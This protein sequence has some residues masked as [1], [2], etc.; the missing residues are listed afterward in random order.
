M[1]RTHLRITISIAVLLLTSVLYGEPI[2][3]TD[4]PLGSARF[5]PT[6]ERP[7]GWRGDG[8]GKYPGAHPP[9]HWGRQLKQLRDL[10]CAAAFK[11][12]S[13]LSGTPAELGFFTDW[14]VAGPIESTTNA[15]AVIKDELL[16]G[17]SA[18]APQP[19]DKL[20]SVTWQAVKV[21]DSYIDVWKTLGGLT[22]GQAA[23]AQTCLY[24]T[25]PV[26]IW[27]HLKYEKGVT[28]WL[29]GEL[30]HSACLT[31]FGNAGTTLALDLRPGWNRFLF[32]L[33]P[34]CTT[35]ED[36]PAACYIRNRFWPE[37]GARDYAEQNIAWIASMPGLSQDTPVIAGDRIFT[38][39][40]P[41]N[42]V[43]LNKQTGKILW[44]R[45]N[46]TYDAATQEE[47]K[48]KPELFAKMDA[49]AKQ[50]EQYYQNFIEGKFP[51]PHGVQA[52]EE[53]EGELD[54]LMVE[55]D[56]K[57]KK[58][59]QQ[60]EPDWWTIPTP[61]TDGKNI[62]VWLTR[63]IS[64]AYDLNGQRRWIS[65]SLPKGQHHGYFCSPVIAD[66]KFIR[67]DGS[68]TAFDIGTG[69]VKWS[70]D[71]GK[72]TNHSALLWFGSL[73]RGGIIGGTEYI[74]GPGQAILIRARDGQV[75]GS[76]G[77]GDST[78]VFT[79]DKLVATYQQGVYTSLVN[80]NATGELTITPGK[81]L[82]WPYKQL[83]G[84]P[85]FYQGHWLEA[86]PLIHDGL[87][88]AVSGSGVLVVFDLATMQPVYEKALSLDLFHGAKGRDFFGANVTLAGPYIYLMGS[89]GVTLVIKPG[90]KYEEVA[91]NRIQFF[92]QMA[93]RKEGDRTIFP[94][95]VKGHTLGNYFYFG[96][97][98]RHCPEY[99]DCT[100]TST[101]I[102]D[103]K[104]MYFRSAENLYCIEEKKP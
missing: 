63:G 39:A 32:K 102:F 28:L 70:V 104:R 53:L 17:E 48:S 81:K 12:N 71:D 1:R 25:Q 7:L 20:G 61:T 10:K 54:K 91:R 80:Q 83:L 100:M 87:G 51:D 15:A 88:Y 33:V 59:W 68:V 44:I 26:K 2:Q 69:D 30:K 90:R 56:S 42:L 60:G 16:P 13:T 50:R 64:A 101:P 65:Y 37:T 34:H 52:E 5:S 4:E 77:Y 55:V 79:G 98:P 99:Q 62:C 31:Y 38:M 23:Y 43:C 27:L 22:N 66:G 46:S 29:N 74:T 6:S 11:D 95:G 40:Y 49:L 97:N 85:N 14:L 75:F 45:Q 58:P 19:G 67:Y 93:F 73:S 57:Y 35:A 78:P 9:V 8:S 76:F 96:Y 41:Y 94:D 86:A 92:A 82:N 3:K 24:S 103:G 72:G 47:R 36:F 89:T 21:E 18:F 84:S